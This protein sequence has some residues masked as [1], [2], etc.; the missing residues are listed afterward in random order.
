MLTSPCGGGHAGSE[1]DNRRDDDADQDGPGNLADDQHSQQHK[2]EHGDQ[3][4]MRG[5]LS[6]PYR[7]SGNAENHQA[8]LVQTDEGEE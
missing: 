5:Q 2:A 3:G 7:S 8:R 4:R 1:G 6:S